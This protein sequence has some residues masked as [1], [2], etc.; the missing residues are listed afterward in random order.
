MNRVAKT[1]IHGLVTKTLVAASVIGAVLTAGPEQAPAMPP[2][3]AQHL[4]ARTG[5]GTAPA[6]DV[7]AMTGLSFEHAVERMLADVRRTAMTPP[8]DWLKVKPPM[9]KQRKSWDLETR[10][11]FRK[12]RRA[13]GRDLKAW[14]LQEMIATSSPFTERMVLFWHNHFTSS[15]RKVKWP[16]YLYAQNALLRRHA[17]GNF[18][19][20]VQAVVM[21]PAMLIYLD[22]R[23]NK[24]R[25]PNENFA[26]EVLEL[27]TMGEGRGYTEHDIR[28][29]ARAFTGWQ[30]D[31]AKGRAVLRTRQHDTGIK[32]VLGRRGRLDGEAVVDAI[33]AR[34]EVA[35]H[36]TEKL[37]RAF[38][39]DQPDPPTV[40]RLAQVFRNSGYE[41]EPL[42]KALLMSDGFR[43]PHNRHA[44]IKSP[45][46][47]VVGTARLAGTRVPV[48]RMH[49]FA[50][51]MGQDLF[52]P[53]NVKGWPG[54][55][56]WVTTASLPARERFLK[57]AGRGWQRSQAIPKAVI[58]ELQSPNYQVK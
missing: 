46:D 50:K 9:A 27:F 37:W 22:G 52:D 12:Q 19:T 36:V 24:A 21:D 48:E 32:T 10:K 7:R 56:A 14:W 16:G 5:F 30:I 43:D 4:L 57:R 15:L 35:E 31:R 40:R 58:R 42:M 1:P 55:R 39:S 29:A 38:V 18:R 49:K 51:A 11:Q 41:I 3:D 23:K 47:L 54:G 6:H 45:V 25:Q 33:L 44:L 17:L 20:L 53:P 8:P 28:E 34:P 13:W 26:R 2:A